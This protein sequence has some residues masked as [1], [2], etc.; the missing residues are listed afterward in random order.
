[1]SWMSDLRCVSDTSECYEQVKDDRT[2]TPRTKGRHTYSSF[3]SF[4]ILGIVCMTIRLN[5]L[6]LGLGLRPSS[7]LVKYL[8]GHVMECAIMENIY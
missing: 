6:G 2:R 7:T 8:F 4:S 3:G 1:M 5:T